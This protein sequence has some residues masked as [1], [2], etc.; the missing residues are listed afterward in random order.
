MPGRNT[1]PASTM[2]A[3]IAAIFDDYRA[4]AHAELFASITA[5]PPDATLYD[6][7]LLVLRV[8]LAAHHKKT[9]FDPVFS[10][11]STH[12]DEL[13]RLDLLKA[14]P[15]WSTTASSALMKRFASEI[16]VKDLEKAEFLVYQT[17]SA[18]P[19][20]MLLERPCYI[21]DEDTP[22]LMARMLHALLT[23]P[24]P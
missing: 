4:E 22:K 10:V 7:I 24:I 19:R 3:L 18:L 15:L 13:V 9:L 6:G 20:A 17:W 14:K 12:Y 8:V 1:C 23:D 5:L 2:E 16:R 11:R 21:T